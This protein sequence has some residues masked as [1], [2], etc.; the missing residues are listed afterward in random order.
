MDFNKLVTSPDS[1][2]TNQ[3]EMWITKANESYFNETEP[4]M[5]DHYYDIA[6]EILEE[7]EPNNKL[8]SQI[9]Q[10]IGNVQQKVE[11]PFH[12]GSMNKLKTQEKV[13]AWFKKYNEQEYIISDKL[14]GNSAL[15]V[16]DNNNT[17]NIYSRGN[18]TIGQNI[19]HLL[20][21][22]KLPS[23]IS[24]PIVFRG[25]L[26][27]SKA[28]FT[29]YNTPYISARS[30][31]N[32]LG[33][34]KDMKKHRNYKIDFVVFEVV[35][36]KMGLLEQFNL[37][38][39]FGMKVVK[40]QVYKQSQ[41][42]QLKDILLK[43]RDDAEYDIDGIIVSSMKP[44][45]RNTSGNPDYSFAFKSNGLGEITRVLDV[46]WNVS[47]HGKIVPKV[48]FEQVVLNGS[49]VSFATGT[50]AKYISE[51]KI[52]KGTIIR[53]V[54]SGDVIPCIID[55]IEPSS[56]A[57]MPDFPYEWGDS[58][59][60]IYIP[61]NSGVS[62]EL[63]LTHFFKTL[64]M[65][66]CGP[67]IVE[68][69]VEAGYN[70]ID[71]FY[72]LKADD[73]MKID[74][75]QKKSAEKLV[76]NLNELFSTKYTAPQVAHASLV[77]G[78]GMGTRKL[79][80]IENKYPIFYKPEHNLSLSKL[81]ELEGFSDKTSLKIYENLANFRGFL[82]E[83]PYIK[84]DVSEKPKHHITENSK[85]YVFSGFRNEELKQK[86]IGQGHIVSDTLNKN[87]NYLIVKDKS[88]MSSKMKKAQELGVEIIE[89]AF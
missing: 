19:N 18:G 36:D 81:N 83:H 76:E 56:E 47:K 32:A 16:I 8:L 63:K 71:S 11:L 27:V 89:Y 50:H 64:G 6:I 80:V 21:L 38:K 52:N 72:R 40:H 25:E 59:V 46:Q 26:I 49:K 57:M 22:I 85:I 79:Q 5:S 67:G 77:F 44:Q 13:Q 62:P 70:T 28:D 31:I 42:N 20:P 34:L 12:M 82:Q 54:L 69:L 3:L 24:G 84:I 7:R 88:K 53:V 68:R 74:G 2:S 86:L 10:N 4:F 60:N 23:K 78:D 75:F 51:N 15:L 14:D 17:I 41:M 73:L 48:K 65:K 29:K 58:G 9:G 55:I 39:S 87:T 30:L 1:I 37:A 66:G 33:A 43:Y 35:S 61:S 45:L